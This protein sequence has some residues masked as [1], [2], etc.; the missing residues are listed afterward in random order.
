MARRATQTFVSYVGGVK[1]LVNRGDIVPDDIAT[2]VLA[3]TYDDG[4][5][6]PAETPKPRKRAAKKAAARSDD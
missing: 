4:A 6:E 3:H 5:D 2:K 1:R